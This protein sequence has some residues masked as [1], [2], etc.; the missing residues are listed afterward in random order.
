MPF[1]RMNKAQGHFRAENGDFNIYRRPIPKCDLHCQSFTSHSH[2]TLTYYSIVIYEA[3]H[4]L[5]SLWWEIGAS[6][7]RCRINKSSNQATMKNQ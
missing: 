5:E 7:I 3:G 4:K 1:F 6:L 2:T